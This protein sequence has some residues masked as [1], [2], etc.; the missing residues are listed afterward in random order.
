MDLIDRQD[1]IDA[2]ADLYWMDE[3]L[4]NFRKEIDA[5]FDKI[6]NLPS[7]Q[8]KII[9]CKD[10]KYYGADDFPFSLCHRVSLAVSDTTPD[11]EDDDFCSRGER[12]T[13]E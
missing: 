1:A 13:N 2:V 11:V 4:L 10:C 12:R 9:R 7:V 3:R 5:V 6:R 8:S